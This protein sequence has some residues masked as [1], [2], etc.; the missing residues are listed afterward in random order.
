MWHKYMKAEEWFPKPKLR[1][2][3]TAM[4]RIVS[5]VFFAL[6]MSVSFNHV[7]H[8]EKG[9]VI[10]QMTTEAIAEKA[11]AEQHEAEVK[12]VD[13]A[14]DAKVMTSHIK[15]RAHDTQCKLISIVGGVDSWSKDLYI[16]VVSDM[17]AG[18]LTESQPVYDS[19]LTVVMFGANPTFQLRESNRFWFDGN[20]TDPV[21]GLD[22]F[23]AA[24][25]KA[26]YFVNDLGGVHCQSSS[27]HLARVAKVREARRLRQVAREA[28]AKAKAL[29]GKTEPKTKQKAKQKAKSEEGKTSAA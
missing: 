26:D 24:A 20:L 23:T 16:R 5:F 14:R 12:D 18:V 13:A 7:A 29:E 8:A 21:E 3:S 25:R 27:R 10:S 4:N 6:I 1:H 19:N 17:G 22:K 15:T 28:E 2:W 9:G 11:S